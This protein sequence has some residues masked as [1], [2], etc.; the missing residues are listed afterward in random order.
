MEYEERKSLES[1]IVKD[2][3]NLDIQ[4]ELREQASRHHDL[5]VIWTKVRKEKVYTQLFT[6][7]AK[8]F[9]NAIQDASVHDWHL[10]AE[11]NRFHS[12]DWKKKNKRNKKLDDV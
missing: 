10:L 6:K 8:T 2:A 7:S 11:G 4:L 12:G 3:D 5:G 1:R 9:W